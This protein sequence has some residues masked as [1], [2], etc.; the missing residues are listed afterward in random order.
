MLA[1]HARKTAERLTTALVRRANAYADATF[2]IPTVRRASPATEL[3]RVARDVQPPNACRHLEGFAS[4]GLARPDDP[5]VLSTPTRGGIFE[6]PRWR[7]GSSPRTIPPPFPARADRGLTVAELR[8]QL[9]GR[10]SRRRSGGVGGGEWGEEGDEENLEHAIDAAMR[11]MMLD[12]GNAP[13]VVPLA[14]PGRGGLVVFDA[15]SVKLKRVKKMNKHKHR[16]RR[17]RDRNKTK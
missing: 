4:F 1:S 2:V 9:E 11:A 17:K 14:A 13:M 3:E 16:K 7:R 5:R 6:S 12:E 15:A 10:A 8:A